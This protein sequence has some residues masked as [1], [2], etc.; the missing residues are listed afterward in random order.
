MENTTIQEQM[1]T[2]NIREYRKKLGLS[3]EK[4]AKL[5]GSNTCSVYNWEKGRTHPKYPVIW[6]RILKL[7][8]LFKKIEENP[9]YLIE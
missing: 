6:Q 9:D 8:D 1:N 7:C 3:A 2:I 4:F 5:I